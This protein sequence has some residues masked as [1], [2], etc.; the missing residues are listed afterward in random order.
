[1]DSSPTDPQRSGVRKPRPAWLFRQASAIPLLAL[2]GELQV[3]LVTSRRKR[4]WIFPKGVVDRGLSPEQAALQEAHEE[5]GVIGTIEGPAVGRYE[6]A[7]WGGTCTVEVFAMQVT[8]V[9]E[10]WAESRRRQRTVVPWSEAIGLVEP[11]E[12]ARMVEAGVRRLRG[13]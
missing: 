12:L 11:A 13:N 4:K 7:K 9:L 5:A 10:D 2:A 8:Q 6:Y 1:M 3:V